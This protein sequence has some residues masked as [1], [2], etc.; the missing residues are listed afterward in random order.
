M[1][2]TGVDNLHGTEFTISSDHHE[3]TTLLALGAMTG[4]EIRVNNAEPEFSH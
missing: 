1:T 2:I 3:I 4:G